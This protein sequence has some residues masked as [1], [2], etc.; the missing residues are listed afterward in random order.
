[1]FD[2]MRP[3]RHFWQPVVPAYTLTLPDPILSCGSVLG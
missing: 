2:A 3:A 1:L